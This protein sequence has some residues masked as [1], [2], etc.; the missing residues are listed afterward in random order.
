MEIKELKYVCMYVCMY[1]G[2]MAQWL[3]RWT[4]DREVPSSKLSQCTSCIV[5]TLTYEA[6]LFNLAICGVG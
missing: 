3:R 4:G 2:R 5:H 1:V 6:G